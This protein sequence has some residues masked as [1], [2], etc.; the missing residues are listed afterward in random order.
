MRPIINIDHSTI[1]VKTCYNPA[2]FPSYFHCNKLLAV[3]RKLKMNIVKI[4]VT[5]M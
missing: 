1:L 2:I 4:R 3:H 5:I